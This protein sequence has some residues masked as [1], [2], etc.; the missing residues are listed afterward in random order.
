MKIYLAALTALGLS[1]CGSYY[2]GGPL[3]V[4]PEV[5]QT[6]VQYM[7]LKED[8]ASC[9]LAAQTNCSKDLPVKAPDIARPHAR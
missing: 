2:Y 7:S 4:Q 3:Y 8:E 9:R 5:N 6:Y 1:G